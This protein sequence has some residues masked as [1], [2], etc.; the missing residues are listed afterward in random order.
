MCSSDLEFIAKNITALRRLIWI[1]GLL[2]MLVCAA[3]ASIWS[4]T[5]FGNDEYVWSFVAISVII[6]L[7]QLN[8]GELAL[9][10]G[11]QEKKKLARANIIGQTLNAL[12]TIPLFYL[13]GVKAIV[14]AFVIGSIITLTISKYYTYK[15]DIGKFQ[16]SWKETFSM[17]SEM[18]KLGFFLSL[19]YLMSTIVIWVI[20]NYVSSVGG[21]DEVGLYSAGTTIIGNYI[22]LVFA[23]I[24]TDYYP[25]LSA[26]KDNGDLQIAVRTQAE[27][28]ILLLA[29][30]AVAFVVFCK[31]VIILLY[32]SSFLPIEHMMYWSIGAV[33]VQAM[34]WAISYTLLAKAKSSY[35][36]L[37]ELCSTIWGLPIKLIC[38]KYWGLTGFGMATL[39]VYLLYL[40][41]VLIVTKKLFGLSYELSIWKQFFLLNMPIVA[42]IFVKLFIPE[43]WGYVVGTVILV[44]T[45]ITVFNVLNRKM[46]I[47][48]VFKLK[49]L[50]RRTR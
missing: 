23:A 31:P 5:S 34:G 22:G 46:D 12:I 3:F 10:Q 29:P 1:T 26:T 41:Q 14:A 35:F 28:T 21:V 20:R 2:G 18:V 49:I 42:T 45:S 39:I 38:Y 37:N 8:N 6:L 27:L 25:R 30:L 50:K 17:G 43:V 9:L 47:V 36:F 7:D 48:T 16:M 44:A 13:F 32:S 24:A 33:L 19:Q 40:I 4:K 11:M 15:L